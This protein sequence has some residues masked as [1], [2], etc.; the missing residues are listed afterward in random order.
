MLVAVIVMRYWSLGSW[1]V[2]RLARVVGGAPV[3]LAIVV[4]LV[5]CDPCAVTVQVATACPAGGVM[6]ATIGVGVVAI[7]PLEPRGAAVLVGW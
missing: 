5:A 7:C 1:V 3:P 2:S 6:V 4:A